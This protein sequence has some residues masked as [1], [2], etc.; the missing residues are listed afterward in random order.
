MRRA[1]PS[2]NRIVAE[3]NALRRIGIGTMAS[4]AEKPSEPPITLLW[5]VLFWPE[6]DVPESLINV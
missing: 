1:A 3:A 2:I 4:I 6:A 5:N